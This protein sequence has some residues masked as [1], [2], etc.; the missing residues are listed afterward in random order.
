M[1]IGIL[2][3]TG[4]EGAGLAARWAQAGHEIVRKGCMSKDIVAEDDVGFLA[5]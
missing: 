5:F 3:G 4:K 2:G 1:K